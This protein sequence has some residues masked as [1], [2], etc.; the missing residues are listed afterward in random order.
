MKKQNRLI[1]TISDGQ[2]LRQVELIPKP[3]RGKVVERALAMYMGS[4]EGAEVLDLFKVDTSKKRK[5]G[6][7]KARSTSKNIL[8]DVLG[9]Y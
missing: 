4:S 2:L 1:V 6:L 7:N 3:H 8:K 5:E 9:D